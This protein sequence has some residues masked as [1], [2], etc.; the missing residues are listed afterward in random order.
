[1]NHKEP[2]GEM[3]SSSEDSELINK[4]LAGEHPCFD[5]LVERYEHVVF[6]AALMFLR[7]RQSAEDVTQDVFISA[8][9]RLASFEGRSSF[10]TWLRKIT[11]NQCIDYKRRQQARPVSSF[12]DGPIQVADA[13]SVNPVTIA[14]GNELVAGVRAAI[15][16][17]GEEQ[18]GII[19]LREIQGLDYAEIAEVLDIPVGTVRSRLHRAR[20]ELRDVLVR[21]GLHTQHSKDQVSKD[22]RVDGSSKIESSRG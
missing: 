8:Y 18:R 9:R 13:N 1:M 20:L 5:V 12:E 6:N 3:K 7:N 15:D 17:L 19:L 16:L 21:Q 11:F 10:A 22:D 14:E 4:V 2:S